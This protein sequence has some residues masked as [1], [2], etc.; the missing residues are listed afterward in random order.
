MLSALFDG[1][2]HV[3]IHHRNNLVGYIRVRVEE[4]VL[5][6]LEALI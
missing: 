4:D 3:T 5:W 1:Q 2:A 6:W